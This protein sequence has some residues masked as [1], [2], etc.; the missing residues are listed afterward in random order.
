LR[1][2][3]GNSAWV[4]QLVAR[5]GAGETNRTSSTAQPHA[6][7]SPLRLIDSTIL[8]ARAS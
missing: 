8:S 2:V 4:V 7:K 1:S 5:A 6:R 3:A